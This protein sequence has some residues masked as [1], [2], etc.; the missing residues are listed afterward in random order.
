MKKK[1]TIIAAGLCLM[2]GSTTLS[3]AQLKLGAIGGANFNDISGDDADEASE[4]MAV[5]YHIGGFV[6]IGNK[7]MVEPQVLYIRKGTQLES[8]NLNLDYI[9]IPI[10]VRYQLEGGFNF[11]AGPFIGILLGAK[12]DGEDAKDGYKSSDWGMGVGIG[13]Q[14]AGGLGF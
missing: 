11:Q 10:W 8:G 2:L 4:G 7:L 6:N 14:L 9:E 1:L 12:A 3:I 13:Y 5:G